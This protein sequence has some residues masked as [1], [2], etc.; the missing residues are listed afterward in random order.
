MSPACCV[1]YKGEGLTE[2]I[3]ALHRGT[4]QA[5]LLENELQRELENAR[6]VRLLAKFGFINE[7]PE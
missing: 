4:S 2:R 7:R 6:L 3:G 5:D 1:S